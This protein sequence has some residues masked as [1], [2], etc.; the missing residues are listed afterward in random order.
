MR[1]LWI[2]V[3]VIAVMVAATQNIHG[4]PDD[5]GGDNR[6]QYPPWLSRSFVELNVGL[7]DTLFDKTHPKSGYRAASLTTPSL[8]VRLTLGHSFNKYFSAQ[9]AYIRPARWA[10]Y[11]DINGDA[12]RHTVWM[13]IGTITVRA[14]APLNDRLSIFGE[15]G[16]GIVTRHGFKVGGQNVVE[17]ANYAT[18]FLGGGIRYR[19]S[20]RWSALASVGHVPPNEKF[21]QP[22]TLMV[23]GGLAFNVR[24]LS[25]GK[26][27]ENRASGAMFPRNLIQ[28]GYTTKGFGTGVN[29]FLAQNAH[30]FWSGNVEVAD[31]ITLR[32]HRN[33]FHTKT[34]F[35]LDWG[36]SVGQW[37]SAKDKA[38]FTTISVF[39]EFRFTFLRF[40]SAD[41]YLNYSLAGPTFISKTL[42][43]GHD[44]GRRFTFQDFMGLG[45]HA[46]K[47][48]RFNLEIGIAHYSNGNLFPQ[49]AGVK[50]PLTLSVGFTF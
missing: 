19:L 29:Q 46:G 39:P 32:Y 13:N 3:G 48:R 30:I 18:L 35:S 16:L 45:F 49:N 43:D 34:L 21:R 22:R 17:D 28:V 4:A 24:P 1:R 11:T 47:Q 14:T 40:K 15:S 26:V 2:A 7:V 12:E 23:T 27:A 5:Q 6:T 37:R 42:I 10:A 36:T 20:D 8:G 31:G 50:I 44:T 38:S 9:L 25:A 33:I 41:V